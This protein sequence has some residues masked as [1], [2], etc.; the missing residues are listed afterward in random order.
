M[1][2]FI[3]VLVFSQMLSV[4]FSQDSIRVN[5]DFYVEIVPFHNRISFSNTDSTLSYMNN[6]VLDAYQITESPFRWKKKEWLIFGGLAL[7]TGTLFLYEEEVYTSFQEKIE[8]VNP[9]YSKYFFEPL[10]DTKYQIAGIAGLYA[11]GYLFKSDKA[12]VL[13]QLTFESLMLTGVATNFMKYVSGRSRPHETNPLN[14]HSWSGLGGNSSFWSGHTATVFSMA[15]VFSS[16][17]SDK[18]WV[19]V[20]AYSLASLAGISRI[21]DERHWV[22]DVVVG[23]TIGTVIGQMVVRN[24]KSRLVKVTP[25]VSVN[26]TG[27]TALLQF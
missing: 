22:S 9:N 17:Y 12:M 13:A 2:R 18:P 21:A 8:G 4:L 10:G 3:F 7:T 1:K 26:Y 6:V 20:T 27:F 24:Y 16:Y 19:G 15:S 23:A 25:I 5:K 11:G 14:A